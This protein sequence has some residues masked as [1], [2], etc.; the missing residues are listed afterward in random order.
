M[1][2]EAYTNPDFTW[3]Q[4][5]LFLLL[6]FAG[7]IL[8]DLLIKGVAG[9]ALRDEEYEEEKALRKEAFLQL[10][11]EMMICA[12]SGIAFASSYIICNHLYLL[13]SESGASGF[14]TFMQ[15]WGD[16]KDFALLILICLS[17]V[18]NTIL[19]RLLIPLKLITNTER[20]M[21]R[22][23]GMFY[24]IILLVFLNIMG[25]KNEYNPVMLYY[26]GLMVGRFV[27]F[28]ASFSDFLKAMANVIKNLPLLLLGLLLS[29]GLAWFGF[30]M[31]YLLESNYYI[32]GVLYTHLF[33][34]TAIFIIHNGGRIV[35]FFRRH[36]D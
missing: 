25:D 28:D 33:I 35:S 22:M 21:V 32:V 1:T 12:T 3:L 9:L 31:G 27:Y 29:S 23:L 18:I 30:S 10:F 19:D 5:G 7:V 13:V 8:V 14:E 15:I 17:C 4:K 24:V 6:A 16:W 26:L 34:L 36:R 2:V 11:Y 20:G